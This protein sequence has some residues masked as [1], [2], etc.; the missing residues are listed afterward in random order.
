MTLV[1]VTVVIVN[2]VIVN[3]VIMTV[4]IVTV[5]IVTVVTV[6]VVLMT[7]VSHSHSFTWIFF[8]SVGS[9]LLLAHPGLGHPSVLSGIVLWYKRPATPYL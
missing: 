6:T 7:V 2:V 9:G 5:L 8:F 3:V 4:V 1:I